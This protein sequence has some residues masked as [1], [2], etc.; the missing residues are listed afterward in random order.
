M[1]SSI[2]GL[3]AIA[4]DSYHNLTILPI[5]NYVSVLTGLQKKYRDYHLQ[6][7]TYLHFIYHTMH[8]IVWVVGT[9]GHT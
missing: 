4:D 1:C 7:I 6:V 8:G 9:V 2:K 3:G 5:K